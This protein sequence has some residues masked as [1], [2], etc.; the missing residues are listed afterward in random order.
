MGPFLA[1]VKELFYICSLC[2]IRQEHKGNIRKIF[3][4][5]VIG[6]EIISSSRAASTFM[7]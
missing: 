1:P 7:L 5:L 3:A 4:Y 2:R 6:W